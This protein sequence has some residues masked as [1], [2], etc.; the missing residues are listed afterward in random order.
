MRKY[1]FILMVLFA[2]IPVSGALLF[3][4]KP[5]AAQPSSAPVSGKDAPPAMKEGVSSEPSAAR[6]E[7]YIATEVVKATWGSGE[8]QVGLY[9]PSER[10]FEDAGPAFGPQSFDV[11]E[12]GNI[13]LLDTV[14]ARVVK[15]GQKGD[16]LQTFPIVNLTPDDI[17]VRGDFAYI[18]DYGTHKILK[19]SMSG[20]LSEIYTIPSVIDEPLGGLQFDADGNLMI[21]KHDR[22]EGK[23][24]SRFF[25]IGEGGDEYNKN[26]YIGFQSRD[27]TEYF[28][29]QKRKSLSQE[30]GVIHILDRKGALKRKILLKFPEPQARSERYVYF[31]G[32]DEKEN[33]YIEATFQTS[34]EGWEELI[35]KYNGKGELMA[36]IDVAAPVKVNGSLSEDYARRFLKYRIT[37]KGD[38]YRMFLFKDAV[39]IVKCTHCKIRCTLDSKSDLNWTPNPVLTGQ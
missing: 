26:H 39:K 9:N 8:N 31:R 4:G 2:F 7:H 13:Y 11:D 30:V 18:F 21:E 3:A 23:Y 5:A 36:S 37:D 25:E 20:K 32:L 28:Q 1:T 34:A 16:V 10:G 35:W 17:R 24:F 6:Q 15:Y 29:F 27:G 22:L 33:I 38:I 14:N 19:Y 12:Q